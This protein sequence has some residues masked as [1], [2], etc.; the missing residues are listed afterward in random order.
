[1]AGNVEG[2]KKASV[3]NRA[4]YG[5]DFYK[6]IGSQGGKNGKTGGFWY[7]KYVKGDINF[8]REAGARGGKIS[9]RSAKADN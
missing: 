1:M 4:M 8:I 6:V 7:Q 3:K 2:G 9:K 5:E